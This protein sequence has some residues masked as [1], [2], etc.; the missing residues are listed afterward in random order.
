MCRSGDTNK[1]QAREAKM[2]YDASM[3]E[4]KVVALEAYRFMKA[5]EEGREYFRQKLIKEGKN[6]DDHFICV[7]VNIDPKRLPQGPIGE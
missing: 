2:W 1:R 4:N 6:P 3:P 7:Y 5:R